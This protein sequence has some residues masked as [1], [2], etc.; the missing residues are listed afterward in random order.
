MELVTRILGAIIGR[1]DNIEEMINI[2]DNRRG[3]VNQVRDMA[4]DAEEVG[5]HL[6]GYRN[7]DDGKILMN[8]IKE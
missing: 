4:I 5:E 6:G 2:G 7:R 3:I 1:L 8:S